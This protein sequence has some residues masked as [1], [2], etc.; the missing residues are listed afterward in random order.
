MTINACH[1]ARLMWTPAP[2]HLFAFVMTRET[3]RVL[4]F[5]R[6]P[7]VLGETDRNRIF[8]TASFD[9]GLAWSMAV[10][11]KIDLVGPK[12]RGLA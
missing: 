3:S 6:R 11:M 1:G 10:I 7:G 4:L 2:E 12:S 8:T 5:Y 9:V